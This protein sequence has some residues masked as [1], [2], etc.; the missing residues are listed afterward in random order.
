MYLTIMKTV[1]EAKARFRAVVPLMML[2]G[3]GDVLYID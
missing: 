3:Y 1:R 2:T